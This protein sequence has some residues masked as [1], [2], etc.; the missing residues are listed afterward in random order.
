MKELRWKLRFENFCKALKTLEEGASR[1]DQLTMLEQEGLIQRFE[2]T[3]ELSWKTMQD[4]LF[5]MGYSGLRGPRHVIK[6]MANDDLIDPYTWDQMLE[7]RNLLTHSYNEE[8]SRS[9][10]RQVIHDF[11]PEL[12]RFKERMEAIE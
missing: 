6:Q 3:F 4:Y 1:S 7:A 12:L 8:M 2:F 5:D 9:Y 10:V 11:L